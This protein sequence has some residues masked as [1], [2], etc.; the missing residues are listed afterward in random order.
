MTYVSICLMD[1]SLRP[2]PS[3]LL[4]F[5]FRRFRILCDR[6]QRWRRQRWLWRPS[7]QKSLQRRSSK[8]REPAAKHA[9][10]GITLVSPSSAFYPL[11]SS[12]S[13][14][15]SVSTS[16]RQSVTRYTLAMHTSSTL[17]GFR[18][19]MHRQISVLLSFLG[20]TEHPRTPLWGG[21]RRPPHTPHLGG[22]RAL[23]ASTLGMRTRVSS[24]SF[25][26]SLFFSFFLSFFLGWRRV[27]SHS[28]VESCHTCME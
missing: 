15:N 17:F 7:P 10:H 3:P 12:S 22:I 19:T 21:Y 13:F 14:N 25:D 16:S 20:D 24:S 9:T 2:P 26:T 18:P 4:I 8:V 11:M 23:Y 1:L 27:L 28:H 6:T 5:S